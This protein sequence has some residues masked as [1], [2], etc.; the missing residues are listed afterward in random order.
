M[1]VA[2]L[3]SQYLTCQYT[4]YIQKGMPSEFIKAVDDHWNEL[5][6]DNYI[7]EDYSI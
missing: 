5:V 1:Y 7:M 2:S 6:D 4:G 3:E